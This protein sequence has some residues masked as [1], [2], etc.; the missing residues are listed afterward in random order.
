[1][2]LSLSSGVSEDRG[3]NHKSPRIARIVIVQAT[4]IAKEGDLMGTT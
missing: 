3:L 1:M 2:G 4:T